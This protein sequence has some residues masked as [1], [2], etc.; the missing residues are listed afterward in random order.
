[1]ER[2]ERIAGWLFIPLSFWDFDLYAD[3]HARLAH[4]SFTDYAV[5]SRGRNG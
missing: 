4:L 1:M 3:P 5:L 2:D